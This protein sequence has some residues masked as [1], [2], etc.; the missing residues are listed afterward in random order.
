MSGKSANAKPC[1]RWTARKT[2]PIPASNFF[3]AA[4]LPIKLGILLFKCPM[5]SACTFTH[6]ALF[7]RSLIFLIAEYRGSSRSSLNK[8]SL[9]VIAQ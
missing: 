7:T 6:L 3:C 2:S 5:I 9:H 4:S 8:S 1:S